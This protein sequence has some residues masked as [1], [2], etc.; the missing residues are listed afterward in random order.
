MIRV[1]ER[2]IVRKLLAIGVA[3]ADCWFFVGDRFRMVLDSGFPSW[4]GGGDDVV[5]V[6]V[7]LLFPTATKV[8]VDIII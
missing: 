6:A 3:V 7:A 8:D 5:I 4:D 1:G 2:D